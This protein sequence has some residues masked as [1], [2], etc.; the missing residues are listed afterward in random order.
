[1]TLRELPPW[2]TRPIEVA[3]L[4]N[5]AFIAVLLRQTSIGYQS[6]VQDGMPY[7]LPFLTLP[8]VLHKPT[9][10]SLP[11]TTRTTLHTW[12]VSQPRL[13]VGFYE[14]TRGLVPFVKEGLIFGLSSGQLTMMESGCLL[15]PKARQRRLPWPTDSEPFVCHKK[16]E[17]VGR[18]F[19]RAGT[20]DTIFTLLGVQV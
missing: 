20:I 5:P 19:A 12:L 1:M 11:S 4:L 9:R 14:R 7:A 16:A 6:E 13:Q 2:E 3:N 15:A 17:F 8:L 10:E 18:W